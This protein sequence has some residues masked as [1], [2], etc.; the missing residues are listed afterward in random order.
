[1]RRAA[2]AM[3]AAALL[4]AIS[5]LPSAV[6]AKDKTAPVRPASA[7]APN[8]DPSAPRAESQRAAAPDLP[9]APQTVAKSPASGERRH[10]SLRAA[11]RERPARLTRK[12]RRALRRAPQCDC[13]HC[14][15]DC[16]GCE[17]CDCDCGC[18]GPDSAFE[19]VAY[20][21]SLGLCGLAPLAAGEAGAAVVFLGLLG[22][23]FL[24]LGLLL[25]LLAIAALFAPAT[26]AET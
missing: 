6:Q 4:G 3:I 18:Q 13:D 21:I 22:G 9:A 2:P 1:M 26:G 7:C 19:A 12:E 5:V 16:C 8:N 20:C 25:F 15:C 10:N 24:F 23:F 11:D 17:D 14:D